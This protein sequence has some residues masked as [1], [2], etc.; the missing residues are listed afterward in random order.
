MKK[1]SLK[2]L[3]ITVPVFKDI[4]EA[5]R[6][7]QWPTVKEIGGH[8]LAVLVISVIIGAYL[9]GLDTLFGNLRNAILFN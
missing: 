4:A 1:I 7:I 3:K 2:N 9:G 5:F 8:L 6:L